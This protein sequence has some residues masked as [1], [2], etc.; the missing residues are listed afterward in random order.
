MTKRLLEHYFDELTLGQFELT[1]RRTIT[2]TDVHMWSM[3]TGDWFPLHT[4]AIAA[5]INPYRHP[6]TCGQCDLWRWV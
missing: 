3:F 2:E 5:H 1:P 4:D 6:N